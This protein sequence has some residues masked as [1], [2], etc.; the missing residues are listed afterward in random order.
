[1]SSRAKRL[2]DLPPL[3][4]FPWAQSSDPHEPTQIQTPTVAPVRE[5]APTPQTEDRTADIEREAFAQGYAQGERA[6]AEAAAQRAEAML[7]R[8]AHTLDELVS[9]RGDMIHATERQ[10]V[11]LALTIARRV[12][13]REITLDRDLLVAMAHV[14][15]ER[16][17]ERA[18]AVV[19]LHPD[20][21]DATV[22]VRRELWEGTSVSVTADSRVAR[23]GCRIESDFGTIDAGVDAQLQEVARALLGDTPRPALREAKV[24]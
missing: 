6:G 3:S 19:R 10:L 12:L 18:V 13:H 15:L 23:G 22:G 20:D 21:F 7:R 1:M 9:L 17:G 16:L 24:A 8:L 4:P 2:V 5:T 14:A 11:E